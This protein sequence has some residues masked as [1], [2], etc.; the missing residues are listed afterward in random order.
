MPTYPV[1][2]PTLSNDLLTINRFLNNPT[3]VNRAMR[4]I[5]DEQ[6]VADKILTGKVQASGGAIVYGVSESIYSDR[7]PRIVAPGSEYPRA[8][9]PD[10]AAALLTVSKYGQDVPL[11]DEKIGREKGRGAQQVMLKSANR[12]VQYVDTITLAAIATAVTQTQA[13][14]A[15]WSSTNTAD[16]LLDVMLA[17]AQIDDLGEGYGADILV[18]DYLHAA[19]LVANPKVVA[20]TPR[21]GA[22]GIIRTGEF[23]MIGSLRIVAVPTRRLPPG[24]TALVADSRQLGFM[25][26]E[27][28]PSPEYTGPADGIQTWARRDPSANDQWLIRTRRVFAP[29]VQEPNAA[30]KITG[31]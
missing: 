5:A 15:A 17:Q 27:D 8:L 25:G 7:D 12:T 28:I 11:T 24:V 3:A 16:P 21:E 31:A 9:T 2:A 29:A 23:P 4:T 6:F 19:R 26:Y 22:N 1:A 10:G 30:V 14:V 18:T 20:A 13:A